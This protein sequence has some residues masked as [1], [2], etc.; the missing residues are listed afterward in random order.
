MQHNDP[1]AVKLFER[2][3]FQILRKTP[4]L[5]LAF[6]R[7]VHN[8][9]FAPRDDRQALPQRWLA[10]KESGW[11][12]AKERGFRHEGKGNAVDWL[13]YRHTFRA[14]EGQAKPELITDL[15]TFNTGVADREV[16]APGENWVGDLMLETQVRVERQEGEI[17]LE[18]VKGVDRFQARFALSTGTCKLVRIDRTAKAQELAEKKT[19]LNQAGGFRLRFANFDQRLTLWIEGELPFGDGVN[20]QASAAKGPT[21]NDLEPVSIASKGGAF[22]VHHLQVW[23]NNYYTVE[24]ARPDADLR[25]E[26]WC[27]PESWRPLRDLPVATFFVQPGHFLFLGDNSPLSSDSRTWGVVPQN[28]IHWQIVLR[29]SPF[30]RLGGLR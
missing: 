24:A 7:L 14:R 20:Y 30:D 6:R 9:D 26:D 17:W 16:F 10:S 21:N 1:Q 25:R 13:R 15:H 18:L 29:Y 28:L 23:R 5:M 11:S 27:N 2:G 8:N 12:S 3:K 22:Q 19:S 4:T